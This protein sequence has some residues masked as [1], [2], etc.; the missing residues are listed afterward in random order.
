VRVMLLSDLYPP[1]IGGLEVHVQSLARELVA[2]G[3]K[4]V[5]VTR[6]QEGQPAEQIDGGVTIHRI[7]GWSRVLHGRY[8]NPAY[9]F[10]PPAP[11][12]GMGRAILQLARRHR[13]DVVHAHSWI[14]YSYLPVK[15]L[16]RAPLVMTLH[17]YG[18]GCA[19]KSNW[20]RDHRC[21]N[22]SF[23]S[24]LRCAPGQYGAGRGI[25][26]ATGLRISR[27]LHAGVDRFIAVSSSVAD[28]SRPAA[29]GRV[30]EVIPNFLPPGVEQLGRGRRPAFLPEQDGYILYVGA[31]SKHKGVDVLLSAHASLDWPPLVLLGH[32]AGVEVPAREGVTVASGV[33]RDDVMAA[34][35]GACVGVVPS[36]WDEPC[37]TV[38]LEAMSRG[39]PL[40]ASAV[41]GLPDLVGGAGLLVPPGDAGALAGA[42]RR[43]VKDQALRA[44]KSVIAEWRAEGF[45]A[46]AIVP[47]IERTYAA[48]L[49]ERAA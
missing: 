43:L 27:S 2:R 4:V 21:R 14:A 13:P 3:H 26:L 19:R 17:D 9:R 11:D 18:L 30:I 36:V 24:C 42:L 29:R 10:A 49:Q 6:S 39:V 44:E 45:T 32:E 8:Q 7:D 15:R 28:V 20:Q 12:P 41:G 46:E 25:A 1:V 37:P 33:S 22:A 48:V 23:A 38:A 40:V 31:L 16:V 5:V 34:W 47:R 35:S